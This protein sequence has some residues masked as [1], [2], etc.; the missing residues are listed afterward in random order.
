PESSEGAALGAA[1]Q[2]LVAHARDRGGRLTIEEACDAFVRLDDS[3][4]VEPDPVRV[5]RYRELQDLH[6]R[7]SL[8]LRESFPRHRDLIGRL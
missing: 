3:S 4:R 5:E 8:A 7:L 6:D 2:A 1:V